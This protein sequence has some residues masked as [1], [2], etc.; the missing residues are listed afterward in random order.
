MKHNYIKNK[1][2]YIKIENIPEEMDFIHSYKRF[3]KTSKD[4]L[5][6]FL[7]NMRENYCSLLINKSK[8]G[9]YIVLIIENYIGLSVYYSLDIIYEELKSLYPDINPDNLFLTDINKRTTTYSTEYYRV[10][11]DSEEDISYC[12]TNFSLNKHLE[13]CDYKNSYS[14]YLKSLIPV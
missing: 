12:T 9:K 7:E 3:Y 4:A 11:E 6:H 13:I 1:N 2:N 8:N 5:N 10:D 14:E